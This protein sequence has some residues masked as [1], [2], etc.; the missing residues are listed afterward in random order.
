MVS[1]QWSLSSSG[2]GISKVPLLYF[3]LC[4]T[5][6]ILGIIKIIGRIKFGGFSQIAK[7]NSMPTFH[8]NGF[9]Y[10][11]MNVLLEHIELH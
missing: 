11:H 5:P 9:S 6:C 7:I 3:T 10:M 1:S 2:I 4:F 8:L